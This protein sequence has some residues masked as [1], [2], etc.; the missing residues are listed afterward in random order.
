V[1]CS[2]TKEVGRRMTPQEHRRTYVYS[3][4]ST[5]PMNYGK[6]YF[7]KFGTSSVLILSKRKYNKKVSFDSFNKMLLLLYQSLAY[8]WMEGP[9]T[10]QI[11]AR[12]SA[13]LT[14]ADRDCLACHFAL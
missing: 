6:S 12:R 13:Q 1:I 4:V 11:P 5:P 14:L 2:S 8:G 7:F 10:L 9:Q 3:L